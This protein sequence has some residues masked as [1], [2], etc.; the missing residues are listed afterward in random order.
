MIP[1]AR[2]LIIAPDKN[3]LLRSFR[4]LAF[5]LLLPLAMLAFWWKA[6]V[7]LIFGIYLCFI[8]AAVIG[9]HLAML[10]GRL[11]WRTRSV[12]SLGIAIVAAV[13]AT[14]FEITRPFNL[15]RANL[16]DQWLPYTDLKYA[17][18]SNANL[19]GAYL[20]G[21]NLTGANLN[22][23]NLSGAYL[24]NAYLIGV[25]LT[26][27]N[28]TGAY[29]IDADLIVANLDG[30]HLEG[31]NLSGADLSGAN[32]LIQQQLD[33]ACGDEH[34]QLPPGLQLKTCGKDQ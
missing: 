25:D 30:A 9:M 31:A 8:A 13:A 26:A 7:F 24:T 15:F 20:T 21:A 33:K 19:S 18:F 10:F 5:Y 28:L 12:F 22:V 17:N 4:A 32:K 16:S 34:T 11:S 1:G 27:A 23:A 14:N 3:P 29:L 2:R 6:A